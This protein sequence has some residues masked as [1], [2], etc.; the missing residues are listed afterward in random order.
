MGALQASKKRNVISYEAI[1]K[2]QLLKSN[3]KWNNIFLIRWH[4]AYVFNLNLGGLGLSITWVPCGLNP[5]PTYV[6]QRLLRPKLS[7]GATWFSLA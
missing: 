6:P 3:S 4:M 5:Y 2:V 7:L 1:K